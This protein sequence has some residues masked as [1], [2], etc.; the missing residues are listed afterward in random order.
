MV[1][2]DTNNCEASDTV[3]IK[4]QQRSSLDYLVPDTFIF[5]GTEI[6]LTTLSSGELWY[7]WTPTF[8]MGCYDCSNPLVEPDVTTT[9]TL[10]YGDVN[11][12]FAFDT[13]ITVEVLD[14]FKVTIPNTFTPGTDNLNDTFQPVLYGVEELV[15]MRIFDRWGV[16]VYETDDINHGWNGMYKNELVSH[17]SMYSY[18]IQVRRYNGDIKD[19]SGMVLVITN[20]L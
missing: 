11:G 6:Y 14:E 2:T 12:C 20:G 8:G 13:T 19:Y 5:L 16:L 4:V 7:N 10:E 15:Y 18:T 1:I 17:N 9:Y 3:N